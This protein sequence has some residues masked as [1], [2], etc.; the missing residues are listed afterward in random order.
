MTDVHLLVPAIGA[1]VAAAILS[2]I[3]TP[4]VRRAA[5]RIDAVDHPDARRVNTSPIPRGGGV[6]VAAAFLLVV[7][8]LLALQATVG[9]WSRFQ[10][11]ATAGIAA[12][13]LGGIVAVVLGTLDDRFNLRARWQFAGQ[14]LVAVIPVGLGISVGVIANPFG[15]A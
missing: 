2:L 13:I 7:L 11:P 15:P 14:L 5:H 4:L 12:L 3:L 6:A 8:A 1:F 9:I 10:A